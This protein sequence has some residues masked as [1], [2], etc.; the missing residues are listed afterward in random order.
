MVFLV[1]DEGL[2][3]QLPPGPAGIR[4]FAHCRITAEER[5]ENLCVGK[6]VEAGARGLAVQ[7]AGTVGG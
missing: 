7:R 6:H 3:K 4:S 2:E 1:A 5:L